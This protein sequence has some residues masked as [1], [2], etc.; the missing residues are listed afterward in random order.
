MRKRNNDNECDGECDAESSGKTDV[1]PDVTESV[2]EELGTA[3]LD[4][5][6]IKALAAL[7]RQAREG[8]ATAANLALVAVQRIR[9]KGAVSLHRAKL[10]ELVGN[11]PA[12]AAYLSGLGLDREDTAKRIGH[13]MTPGETEAWERAQD[14]RLLEVRA[15]ELQRMRTMGDVPRWATKRL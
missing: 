13:K 11:G 8:N 14:D 5:L 1:T 9:E 15:V 7:V 3:V 4:A 2:T 10:A 6:E 12:L